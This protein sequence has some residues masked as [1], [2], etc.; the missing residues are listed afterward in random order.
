[1]TERSFSLRE[2]ADYDGSDG[3]EAFVAF[4][5]TVYDLTDSPMW[6]DGDHEGEHA[7]GQD[8]TAA[9]ADA[10]HGAESLVGFPVVGVLAD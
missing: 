9:M 6:I 10:P 2:L 1:M 5:G 7:A 8:L 4:E 3:S